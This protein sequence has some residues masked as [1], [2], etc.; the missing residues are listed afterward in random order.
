MYTFIMGLIDSKK[1]LKV[2]SHYMTM[3]TLDPWGG[4]NLDF[5]VLTRG[6]KT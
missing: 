6:L 3:E 4:P 5:G 2:F 1:I